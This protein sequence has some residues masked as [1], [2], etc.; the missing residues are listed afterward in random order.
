MSAP[1]APE[2][3]RAPRTAGPEDDRAPRTAAT[4]GPRLTRRGALA[5]VPAAVLAVQAAAADRPVP[6]PESLDAPAKDAQPAVFADGAFEGGV[7]V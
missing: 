5:L 1:E 3:D 6:R 4:E 7:F 2:D